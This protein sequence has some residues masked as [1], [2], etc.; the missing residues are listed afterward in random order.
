ML[1][2][3]IVFGA[4]G[5]AVSSF[6]KTDRATDA[7][8]IRLPTLSAQGSAGKVAFETNCVACHGINASG[9]KLGPSFVN[10]IYN[11]GHHGDSAFWHAVLQGV[12]QHHWHFG[13]MPKLPLVTDAQIK[14][15]VRYV[16]ELQVA[17]GIVAQP[18]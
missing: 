9:T 6:F 18:Q 12:R 17:N 11:P 1:L 13:D 4:A 3:A 5:L 15:I 7:G 8:G 16:R 2:V 10:P 14:D